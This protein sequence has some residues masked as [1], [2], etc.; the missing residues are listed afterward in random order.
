MHTGRVGQNC[1]FT[2]YDRIYG[3][4]S[5]K[6]AAYTYLWFWPTLRTGY[7]RTSW[8]VMELESWTLPSRVSQ[9][10]DVHVFGNPN[11]Q[12]ILARHFLYVYTLWLRSLHR[13]MSLPQLCVNSLYMI[14]MAVYFRSFLCQS[15]VHSQPYRSG[16]WSYDLGKGATEVRSTAHHFPTS[17]RKTRM[18]QEGCRLGLTA[19]IVDSTRFCAISECH[20]GS[21]AHVHTYL[22]RALTGVTC[23]C[24]ISECHC[25]SAAHVHTYT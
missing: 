6:N 9:S 8:M 25:G 23:F 11:F 3:D 1:I 14:D 17:E 18:G 5:A 10:T 20:C 22:D 7:G 12:V 2:P 15:Q 24:A 4:L 16:T 13:S 19:W 21:A